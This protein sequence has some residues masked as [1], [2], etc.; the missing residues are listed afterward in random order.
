LGDDYFHQ[1]AE[2]TRSVASSFGQR[3][4]SSRVERIDSNVRISQIY[5]IIWPFNASNS[6]SR[7]HKLHVWSGLLPPPALVESA[8]EVEPPSTPSLL[9]SLDVNALNFCRFSLLPLS[10]SKALVAVPNLV[11]SN[12]VSL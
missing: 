3:V 5:C 1:D 7:D 12:Y 4:G 2:V 8:D 6:H 10:D 9:Y 11:D